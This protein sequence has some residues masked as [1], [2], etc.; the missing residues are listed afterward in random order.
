MDKRLLF[1]TDH[2]DVE[3]GSTITVP[4]ARQEAGTDWNTVITRGLGIVGS[5][6][7]I[8]VALGR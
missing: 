2:P 3:P 5:I 4:Y 7:T 6:A 1:F 8:M